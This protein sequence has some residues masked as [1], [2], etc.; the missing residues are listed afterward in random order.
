MPFW[1]GDSKRKLTYEPESDSLYIELRPTASV[2]SEEVADGIV[3]DFDSE[4]NVV[5]IDIDHASRRADL[6][7]CAI[8]KLPL[9]AG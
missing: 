6:T 3:L 5:G 4:G 2:E 9:A 1:T 7:R 8:E